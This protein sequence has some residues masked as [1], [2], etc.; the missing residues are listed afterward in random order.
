MTVTI[1]VTHEADRNS[2]DIEIVI[3]TT[4]HNKERGRPSSDKSA[5]SPTVSRRS[6]LLKENPQPG[7][8][9]ARKIQS[10]NSMG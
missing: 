6:A 8:S 1:G 9:H 2:K 3:S 10:T 7:T 4:E 5:Q